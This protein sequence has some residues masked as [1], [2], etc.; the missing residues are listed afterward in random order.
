MLHLIATGD[1]KL[2]RKVNKWPAPKWVR[3]AAISATRAGDG[4][5]WYLVGL[6]ILLFGPADRFLVSF[7]ECIFSA[8]LL[9]ERCSEPGSR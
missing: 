5:L 9:S 6:V 3:L 4:W 2:M 7:L 1:H 8:T